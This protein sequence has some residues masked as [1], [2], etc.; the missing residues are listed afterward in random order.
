MSSTSSDIL[1]VTGTIVQES[2]GDA[3]V[4]PV[5]VSTACH[6]GNDCPLMRGPIVLV[7]DHPLPGT[8]QESDSQA[9]LFPYG[10]FVG[11]CC[12]LGRTLNLEAG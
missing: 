1:L 8:E 11:Y 5:T 10:T 3:L 4:L 2:L 7:L 9:P 12:V 6:G